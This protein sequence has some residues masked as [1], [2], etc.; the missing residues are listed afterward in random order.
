VFIT[1]RTNSTI[2]ESSNSP[3]SGVYMTYDKLLIKGTVEFAGL[4][5]PEFQDGIYISTSEG[6]TIYSLLTENCGFSDQY[7][8]ERIKTILIDGGPVDDIFNIK[9]KEGGVCALSGA[10][11]GIV[12]AMMRIGSPYASMRKSITV[13]PDKSFESG[14]SIIFKIKLFNMILSDMGN[15]FLTRGIFIEK[16]RVLNFLIRNIDEI[17]LKSRKII[18]ND[19]TVKKRDVV[20]V[21]QSGINGFI[22]FRAEIADENKS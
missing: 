11:P 2:E 21:V 12:G 15:H 14:K 9:I 3:Q 4:F 6:C 1:G 22:F 8:S 13:G 18:Y 16:D 5:M 17:N 7:I 19:S 10:M 20:E